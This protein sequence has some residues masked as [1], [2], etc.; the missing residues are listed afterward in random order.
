[1]F[2]INFKNRYKVV[3]L[4]NEIGNQL[5]GGAGTYMNELYK[6]RK[7]GDMGFIYVNCLS[8]FTDFSI[9]DFLDQEDIL[10]MHENE[11]ETRLQEI[12][13]DLLVV[14][15]YEFSYLVSEDLKKD[16]KKIAYVIHSVPTPEPPPEGDPFGGNDHIRDK[17]EHLCEV[18]DILICVSNAE[19]EKLI[20][21]YPDYKNKIEVVHNGLTFDTAPIL[22]ENYKN[23][24]RIFGFIGRTD[25]RK[26]IIE[27]IEELENIDAEIRI[28][29]PKNDEEYIE[30]ILTYIRDNNLEDKVKFY[31]WCSGK[32]KEA[33]LKSLDCLIIPSLYEPFGYVA[34]EGMQYGLPI[35][36]SNNGGLDEIFEGYKYKYNPYKV[37]RLAQQV[38]EFK[39]DTNE[40]VEQQQA[41]LNKN[42]R[43]F[44]AKE[45]CDRYNAIWDKV[46][47][48]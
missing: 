22:N 42:L 47:N 11:A 35:I 32:R 37:G 31:G 40:I 27:T 16:G 33:F 6:Y 3:H 34:L 46:I 7:E 8:P 2:N 13:C 10:I 26:G 9:S 24:R 28:A 17:F 12:Q 23:S 43:R 29:C 19:K 36:S 15:F 38:L 14:H 5:V 18:A 4:N 25:Y 21:M 20:W 41:I 30:R 48:N 1:M 39:A 44:T 45:M